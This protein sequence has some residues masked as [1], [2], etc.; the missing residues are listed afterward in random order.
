MRKNSSKFNLK[1][2]YTRLLIICIFA[3]FSLLFLKSEVNAAEKYGEFYEINGIHVTRV[4]PET[5]YSDL[6]NNLEN[7]N[8]IVKNNGNE[9]LENDY[10]G[11]G[12]TLETQNGTYTVSVVGDLDGNGLI[13]ITDLSKLRLFVSGLN[14]LSDTYRLSADI[15]NDGNITITDL[16]QIN[17]IVVKI[18]DIYAPDSFVPKTVTSKNTVTVVGETTD[19]NSGNIEY[20][21]KIDNGNWV[22]NS[23]VNSGYYTFNNID[24]SSQHTVRMKVIDGEGNAKKTAEILVKNH[25]SAIEILQNPITWTNEDVMVFVEY[26]SNLKNVKKMISIDGGN[27]Y[28]EYL[29]PQTVSNNTT[30]VAQIR[31]QSG[32]II[33]EQRKNITNIDKLEPKEFTPTITTQG[34]T[35]TI[36]AT[37]QDADAT[38]LN[39][40]SGLKVYEYILKQDYWEWK[41]TTS[42]SSYTFSNLRPS[43]TYKV[44][45][46]AVDNAGNRRVINN[47]QNI[48]VIDYY[49]LTLD[50][51]GGTTTGQ[52]RLT[53]KEG[54]VV[55][56]ESPTKVGYTFAGWK[57]TGP[58]QIN[59]NSYT[60]GNNDAVLK[61]KWN[62]STNT[63]YTVVHQ[64]MNIDGTTY[65]TQ[66]T[67]NLQAAT[68][69]SVT[70]SV[71]NYPGFTAPST[72]TATVNA[73]GT[74]VITYKYT[75]NKY[76]FTLGT[77]TGVSTAGSSTTGNYYHG[78][79]I[80]LRLTVNT[81]YE[82]GKWTSSN[83]SLVSNPTGLNTTFTMPIGDITM[84][85]SA[86]LKA[87]TI[88][89]TVIHQ[90]M[91]LDGTTYTTAET[92]TLYA[93]SGESVTPAVKDYEGFTAPN[94]QT[95]TI[96]SS[97]TTVTYKY[98]RNRYSYTLGVGRGISTTGSTA[99]GN[100]YYGAEIILR[101]QA[102]D[103]YNS[104]IWLSSNTDI[105]S[106]QNRANTT[107]LM[108]AGNLTMIPSATATEYLITYTLNGGIATNP[109]RYSVDTDDITLNNP[110]KSGSVFVGWTGS[111]GDTP[112]KDVVI[113]K[114][115]K[116]NKNY[117][118]NW[119]SSN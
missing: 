4:L 48:A 93:N 49:V 1:F 84:T 108:P 118:A 57:L 23:N 109:T 36:N 7:N 68:G 2:K 107:I 59:G 27:T 42:A 14:T 65:T 8:I 67:E 50:L 5:T 104:P 116:G 89:Y 53:G 54:E 38:S 44:E 81:G 95:V 46:A 85:P 72:Q 71:K 18:K 66:D 88:G 3:L 32:E 78:Q 10:V 94:R 19:E 63:K 111:N 86:S 110:V 76:R 60:F 103:G 100:Y 40:K 97:G 92:E 61:A 105:M 20:Y 75:R 55:R 12:M 98:T 102:E 77:G 117:I 25:E 87:V 17:L 106:N 79:T 13:T 96:S 114:G 41:I 52:T 113:P 21:F 82:N 47:L 26:N 33:E 83:T 64:K 22:Q 51:N 101:A 119:T 15:N 9:I 24:L 16:T 90:K 70:P 62:V 43:E 31:N 80:T 74:T 29:R 91:N 112:Q 99:S 69:S 30:V 6:K 73:D 34:Q 56:V 58:G 28:T 45:V 39:G 115:S 35:I 11:S 37:T